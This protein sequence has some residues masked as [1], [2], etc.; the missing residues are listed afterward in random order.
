MGSP[1]CKSHQP[2]RTSGHQPATS[3]G[4]S[5]ANCS[6]NP[7]N[8]QAIISDLVLCTDCTYYGG[9]TT[10]KIE[11]SGDNNGEYCL[12][13]S[14]VDPCVYE[15]DLLYPITIKTYYGYTCAGS[16]IET[17]V[18][19]KIMLYLRDDGIFIVL[20]AGNEGFGHSVFCSKV[21][22]TPSCQDVTFTNQQAT[23]TFGF[24]CA[25]QYI[26]GGIMTYNYGAGGTISIVFDGC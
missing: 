19:F 20:G 9:S 1:A 26:N 10:T 18:I 5:C 7:T 16:P 3:C 14:T 12:T 17:V 21:T 24:S 4:G 6:P 15:A 25:H 11:C 23:C 2:V 22:Q 13:Q 8:V